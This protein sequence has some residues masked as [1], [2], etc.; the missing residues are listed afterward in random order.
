MRGARDGIKVGWDI[1]AVPADG[2]LRQATRSSTTTSPAS[3]QRPGISRVCSDASYPT[4]A[5]WTGI[6]A[7]DDLDLPPHHQ[8]SQ[9]D[10]FLIVGEP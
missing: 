7:D 1:S 10:S 6:S 2:G 3:I 5:S 8:G 4:C 9:I